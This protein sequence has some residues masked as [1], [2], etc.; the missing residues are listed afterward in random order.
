[1]NELH[2]Y[3]YIYSTYVLP[4]VLVLSAMN[5]VA[6]LLYVLFNDITS[7][8]TYNYI[9]NYAVY[10]MLCHKILRLQGNF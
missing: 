7:F 9:V 1:M 3:E 6:R 8:L 2:I 10:I 4:K 5:N